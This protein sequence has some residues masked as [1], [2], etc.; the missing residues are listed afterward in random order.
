MTKIL[1]ACGLDC[2]TCECYEAHKAGDDERKND[3][4]IRWSKN[5]DANLSAEDI[6]CD[7]CMSDGTHFS[8]CDKCPIRACVVG[9]GYESCAECADFPCETNAFLYNAVPLAK[10]TIEKLR[11]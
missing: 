6:A 10:E 3:I 5:Y 8:W 9:K 7:G 2:P 1:S 4:A 11:V